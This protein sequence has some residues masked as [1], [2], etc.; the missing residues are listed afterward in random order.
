ML[1]YKFKMLGNF[2]NTSNMGLFNFIIFKRINK[3]QGIMNF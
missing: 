3:D 1:G 2:K